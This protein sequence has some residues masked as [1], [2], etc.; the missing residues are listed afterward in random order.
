MQNRMQNIL[1][2]IQ[3]AITYYFD[4]FDIVYLGSKPLFKH[5]LLNRTGME[6]MLNHFV[7]FSW[8]QIHFFMSFDETRRN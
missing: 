6:Y 2:N 3:L 7:C 1:S 4:N 8:S 5:V